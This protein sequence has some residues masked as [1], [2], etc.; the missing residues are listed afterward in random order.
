MKLTKGMKKALSLL[1]SAAMVVTGVNVTTNAA[2]AAD[3]VP[4]FTWCNQYV[5]WVDAQTE[6]VLSKGDAEYTVEVDGAAGNTGF[7]NF[8]FV[9]Q[10]KTSP[11]GIVVKSIIVNGTKFDTDWTIDIKSDTKNGM[12]NI[13]NN[14]ITKGEKVYVNGENDIFFDADGNGLSY[15]ENG[16]V[17]NIETLSYVFDVT[18]TGYTP[19]ESTEPSED[20]TTETPAVTEPAK[21]TTIPAVT[22]APSAEPT[23]APTDPPAKPA[24]ADLDKGHQACLMF[25]D[26]NWNWGCWNTNKGEDAVV[27]GN[28][29]YTVS[30]KKSDFKSTDVAEPAKGATVFCVDIYGLCNS[31]KMDASKAAIS[32]VIIKTDDKVF[33]A[34][35]TKMY[36]G[37]IEGKGNYRLEICNQYGWDKTG[38]FVT[39]EEFDP[40][41]EFGFEESLSVTFTV[42]GIQEGKTPEKAFLT[43]DA[44]G[45]ELS[46]VSAVG[47]RAAEAAKI[48]PAPKATA[49]APVAKT[50]TPAGV[51]TAT[52]A[53]VSTKSVLGTSKLTTAKKMV[54]VAPGKSVKVGFKATAA[55]NTSGAAIVKATTASKKVATV[56]VNGK[57]VTIKVPKKA[58]KGAS[59]TVTLKST[60]ANGK[61]ISAKIKVY[62]RNSAKKVKAAKKAITVK[63]GK[64]AKLVIKASKVQNKKKA[65]VD[66]ITVKG[67]VLKLTNVKYAKGKATLTL[68]G[69]KKAKKKAV[70]IKVGSKKVKVKAT[71][72]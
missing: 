62:V 35:E 43:T 2:N 5:G 29:T 64:T 11:L 24:P 56:K 67:K 26:S 55:K 28:G 48:T 7:T 22:T 6:V 63:K 37:D 47:V 60:K 39:K 34:D 8:G 61:A 69:A 65:F 45:N 32:N 20:P 50:A 58:V 44:E 10:D 53:A 30:I 49:K 38:D 23:E 40:N 13:W 1:L 42:T 25:T 66:T 36:E 72:K 46:V 54:V 18:N 4:S 3:E 19:V 59:T 12:Y 71:V 21:V 41:G 57:K 68:K 14:K 27:T 70:T 17:K 31:D 52:P 33:K 15:R 51:K 16:E 9:A